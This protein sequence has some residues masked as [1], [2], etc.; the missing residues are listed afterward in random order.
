MIKGE[1]VLIRFPFTN[2]VDGK[3]RP[4][5]VLYENEFDITVCFITTQLDWKEDTDFLIE[6]T[7]QNGLKKTSLLRVSKIATIEKNLAK[8]LLGKIGREQEYEL[9]ASLKKL[10]KLN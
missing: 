2:L 6:P 1:I 5:V 3:L 8:G 7:T 4:A 9:N 10:L